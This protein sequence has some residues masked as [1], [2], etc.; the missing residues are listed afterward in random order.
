MLDKIQKV[1]YNTD[2]KKRKGNTKMKLI[3]N[4]ECG[5]IFPATAKGLREALAEAN[6]LY[7]LCDPT[8]QMSFWNYYQI[9]DLG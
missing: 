1:C 8:N 2:R 6:E 9:I 3:Q 4:I 7:D 5:N